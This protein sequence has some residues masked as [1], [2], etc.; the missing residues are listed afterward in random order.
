VWYDAVQCAF[1]VEFRRGDG[2]VKGEG[3]T[4]AAV[5]V[6]GCARERAAGTVPRL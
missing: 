1:V 5:V 3:G 6:L 4:L 2:A